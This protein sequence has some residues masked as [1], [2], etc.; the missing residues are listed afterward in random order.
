M[1]WVFLATFLAA[2]LNSV[3]NVATKFLVADGKIHALPAAFL[4][5]GICGVIAVVGI[6]GGHVA[7]VAVAMPYVWAVVIIGLLG[8]AL[9]MGAL[10]REDAS[11]VV[12]MLGVKVIFLALLEPL[13]LDKAV[14]PGIW[15]AAV[16]SV[17]GLAF[18]SQTDRWNLRPYHLLRPGVLMMIAAAGVF[19]ISDLLLKQALNLWQGSSWGVT[20]YVLSLQGILALCGLLVLS[21][22]RSPMMGDFS[23]MR[24]SA[25]GVL[26]PTQ[27]ALWLSALSAFA[28][29]YAFFTAFSLGKQ[30]TQINILYNAR[31]LLVILLMALLVLGHHSEVERVGWHAYLYRTIGAVLT[32]CA[33]V[34][35]LTSGHP[36]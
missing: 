15:A 14:T 17:I 23:L 31:N 10:V 28:Y 27:W 24:V 22:L 13:L 12:P 30:I 19:S 16:I 6:L 3:H 33:I 32:L 20:S 34:L 25:L 26:R 29:Q 4:L 36:H 11:V 7:P 8:F 1:E 35:A 21:L 2:F 9:M 5:Q 18:I